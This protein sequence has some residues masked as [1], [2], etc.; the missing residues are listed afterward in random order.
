LRD[1]LTPEESLHLLA[2]LP[3]I[4]KAIYVDGWK[5]GTANRMRSME[6]FLDGLRSNSD[7][8]EIDFGNDANA[9][10]AV[11]CVLDVIQ[12]HVTTGEISH[13]LNQFPEEL[14]VLWKTPE[15]QY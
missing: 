3:M 7:R 2:Q 9:I 14:L 11:Q 13:I 4:L 10:H 12:Q 6:K 1:I 5:P 15:K 8:P